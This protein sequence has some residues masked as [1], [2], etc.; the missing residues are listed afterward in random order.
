[1]T[2]ES[3]DQ[4][5]VSDTPFDLVVRGEQTLTTA[6]IVAREIGIRDGRVVAIEPLGSGLVGAEVIELADDQ[7]MIPGLVDTH[8]HV[9][10]PGRTEWEGFDSATRA[11]AAGGVTTLIDMPLNSIPP[12]VNVD[13][14]AEK[15]A[16]AQG[17]THI[18]VGFWGGAIPGNE[19]DLRGLHDAGV[20]GFKCFLLHSGVDEFPHLTADE[21]EADMAKLAEFDSLMIVHAEDSR[22]IDKAPSPEGD[23]YGRF[24]ASRPRGAENL[25]IAEVIERARWTGVRAHVLHLSSSDALPMLASAKRDGV[26]ITVETCP[27][28]LT[29]LAEE[30]PNG[31]TAFKCCPPIREAGNRELLWEGLLAGTIDC[32]VSDHSPSTVDL[33]DPENGDFGVAWGGVASLQLGLSLI[34]SEAKKRG[35]DLP[36]VIEWMAS[37]PADLAGLPT[38][39]RIALGCD[40]DFAIFEPESAQIVDVNRLHH[41]NPVSPYD[42]RALAGVVTGTWVRGQRVD[43]ETARGRMLRRGD[44]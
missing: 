43:F 31:A 24:L 11:A 2:S 6:G 14:L 26:K 44:V 1:M 28:Y 15:R 13:A 3:G 35:I 12:T 23:E 34:W 16:A 25:A 39:G 33:K 36:Q 17:K 7:V 30:V 4:A 27:H 37:K 40:A 18:D 22:A 21:M 9:N 10:E 19:D 8:V 38:K 5:P 42:G 32:I 41:K 29:L 20:F